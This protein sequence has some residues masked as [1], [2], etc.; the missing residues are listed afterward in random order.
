M[1]FD[2][3]TGGGGDGDVGVDGWSRASADALRLSA[4][5]ATAPPSASRCMPMPPAGAASSCAARRLPSPSR[6]CNLAGV[7]TVVNGVE[8]VVRGGSWNDKAQNCRSAY[9]N[10][11]HP[12]NRNDNLGF[13]CARAHDCASRR[14]P[15][16]TLAR[17]P[18]RQALRVPFGRSQ[19]PKP[20]GAFVA[21]AR[22][23]AHPTG[24]EQP[25]APEAQT[26]EHS[27]AGRLPQASRPR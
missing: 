22:A 15:E 19:N 16:Q 5:R 21:R 13:R 26:G 12:D 25:P 20:P 14:G 10:R 9:R 6:R 4:L 23:A 2:R 24:A 8:P 18:H 11:N 3:P 7:A 17:R 27:P 1:P